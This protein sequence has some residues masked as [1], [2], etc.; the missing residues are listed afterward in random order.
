MGMLCGLA[1]V[2]WAYHLPRLFPGRTYYLPVES[3]A[4][5]VT[6]A[7]AVDTLLVGLGALGVAAAAALVGWLWPAASSSRLFRLLVRFAVIGGASALLFLY[8]FLSYIENNPFVPGRSRALLL[9]VAAVLLVSFGICWAIE[10]FGRAGRGAGGRALALAATSLGAI[11]VAGFLSY[12]SAYTV[13]LPAVPAAGPDAPPIVLF[14]LDTVRADHLGCYGHPVVETPHIDALAADG[15]LF[16]T[17]IAQAPNTTPSHASLMTS[18]Y[19]AA[20]RAINGIAMRPD[21]PTLAEILRAADYRTAAFVSA[22]TVRSTDSGLHRGF[23][24]YDDS[25]VWWT[26]L[27]GRDEFQQL[28]LF[29]GIDVLVGADVPGEVTTGRALRWLRSRPPP[30][31]FVWIHYFDAHEQFDDL[32]HYPNPYAGRFDPSLPS[33]EMREAYG[34]RVHYVDEQVGRVLAELREQ[35]LYD[36]AL[37]VVVSDH[38]EGFGERHGD[39]VEVAH[40]HHLFD[41][42]QLVPLIVKLPGSARAG[43]RVTQQVQLVDLPPT[44]LEM[45]G[46]PVPGSFSG[47]SLAGLLRGR[48]GAFPETAYF[49]KVSAHVS[50]LA[51][52]WKARE[53][54]LGL[55]TREVKYVCNQLGEDEQLYDL[56][57]D[58]GETHNLA[59]QRREQAETLRR[60]LFATLTPDETAAPPPD[61]D[62]RLREKL[63]ALGYLTE[64]SEAPADPPR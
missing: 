41:T 44:F 26:T 7:V 55:R 62:P 31:F 60:Q 64:E 30:P 59:P 61:V 34:G 6:A 13:R 9:S 48:H 21:I 46:L 38:G 16:E 33:R 24:R 54:L 17:A 18:R 50:G 29:Q 53:N 4:G 52:N 42:T 11:A 27:Y 3:F 57:A 12:R 32:H 45:A 8:W 56:V 49:Q 36:E 28:A 25:L 20:H 47:T 58:P 37:I 35:G 15:V 40:S 23:E 10:R 51:A 39:V 14:T 1:E 22:T 43:S 5:F 19:P 63:Q 2:G